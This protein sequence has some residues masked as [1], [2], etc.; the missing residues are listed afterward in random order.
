[1]GCI[2]SH[3]T[4]ICSRSIL[5]YPLRFGTYSIA[6]LYYKRKLLFYDS[7]AAKLDHTKADDF[8]IALCRLP[9]DVGCD[10]EGQRGHLVI[11][12][13][14]TNVYGVGQK[15]QSLAAFVAKDEHRGFF[16]VER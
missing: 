6:L 7:Y 15:T 2:P 12:A 16:G 4:C 5:L 8:I 1:L 10:G 13:V 9:V 11:F 3:S 14:D